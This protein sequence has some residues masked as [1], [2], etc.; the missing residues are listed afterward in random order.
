MS[1]RRNTAHRF[2]LFVFGLALICLLVGWV[3]GGMLGGNVLPRIP[4]LYHKPQ[5]DD[6]A[7]MSR[8]D[9]QREVRR[10]RDELAKKNRAYDDL[11]I[12]VTLM[13]QGS[14]TAK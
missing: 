7:A 10:L 13:N 2:W 14:K 4:L 8:D 11:Q 12:Q 6:L 9:L 3:A 5:G 1:P